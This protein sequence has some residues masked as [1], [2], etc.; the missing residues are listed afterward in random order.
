[1]NVLW[2][3]SFLYKG[4]YYEQRHILY[5]T[6]TLRRA[7]VVY[8]LFYRGFTTYA[9]K[10]HPILSRLAVMNKRRQLQ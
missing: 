9:I 8:C 3:L 5:T 6:P 1:M 2:Q 10:L 4:R 7:K